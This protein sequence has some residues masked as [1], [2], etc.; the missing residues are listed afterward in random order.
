MSAGRA[1]RAVGRAPHLGDDVTVPVTAAILS[2]G[3]ELLSGDVVNTNLAEVARALRGCG[4]RVERALSVPDRR[5]AIVDALRS[6]L[7]DVGMDL[8]LVTGGLGPT[9]DDLTAAS[10]AVACALP[11][12]QHPEAAA[13][14][15]AYLQARGRP[16]EA[17]QLRQAALP[18]GAEVIQNPVGSAPGFA[19]RLAGGEVICMPGVPREMRAM[20]AEGVIPR[21]VARHRLRPTPRRVYRTLG[22]REAELAARV[23]P[24]AA[25]ARAREAL[26]D[27]VV[28]YRVVAPEVFLT[29]EAGEGADLAELDAAIVP[30]LGDALYGI[31][32][33]DLPTRLVAALTAA[34]LTVASA[35]SCTGGRV[36]A[37]ITGVAGSSSCFHGAVVAYDNAIKT[38]ILGVPA[39]TLAEHGAVSEATA[40]A[41]AEGVRAA[42]AGHADLGVGV[43]GIAG[44]SGGSAAKPVGTVDFAVADRAGTSHRRLHIHG[45]RATVQHV[46]AMW[47]LRLVWDRLV[48]RGLAAA[49]EADGPV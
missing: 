20:L 30:A 42:M 37:L 46:A 29:L 8:C 11:L 40:R 16:V 22:L 26:R 13:Q 34:G 33:A 21:L 4:V 3:D 28:H 31:G 45:D 12:A 18:A 24:I 19:V 41:M 6:C 48:A 5:E 25:D 47:A 10:V 43:T 32:E 38:S 14:I 23:E 17:V 35:E 7:V 2:V 39:S 1:H 44:P 36:A 9:S 27:L 49:G 15:T